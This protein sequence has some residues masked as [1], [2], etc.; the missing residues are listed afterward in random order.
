VAVSSTRDEVV[1]HAAELLLEGL[2]VGN[3]LLLVELVLRREGLLESN[4]KSSDGVVVG[5]TL[6]TGED[7]LEC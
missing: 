1:S 6:V 5:T 4:G 3:N 7:T 2:G